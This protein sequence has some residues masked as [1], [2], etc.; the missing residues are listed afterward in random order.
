M[1]YVYVLES[2]KDG[3]F[4]TGSTKDLKIRLKK[5]NNG[6]VTAT[7]TRRPFILVYYEASMNRRDSMRR[8]LYLKTSWGKKYLKSRLKYYIKVREVPVG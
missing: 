2:Q 5:H 7:K 8:E 3:K 1:H 6:M 4:Y